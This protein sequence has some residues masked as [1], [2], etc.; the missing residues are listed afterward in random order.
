MTRVG[1]LDLQILYMHLNEH[2]VTVNYLQGNVEFA[3]FSGG[4]LQ[5]LNAMAHFDRCMPILDLGLLP[6]NQSSLTFDCHWL[7]CSYGFSKLNVQRLWF[8]VECS[9]QCSALK[10]TGIIFMITTYHIAESTMPFI[11]QIICFCLLG[12]FRCA[13]IISISATVSAHKLEHYGIP[14]YCT[15]TSC[16]L[17]PQF[18]VT[19]AFPALI[20][21][22]EFLWKYWLCQN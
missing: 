20:W 12:L 13:A 7:L 1:R 15:L 6:R 21:S 9:Q 16:K 5:L 17:E 2:I 4:G 11:K 14:A 3:I 19:W 10:Q 22:S 8:L 18:T